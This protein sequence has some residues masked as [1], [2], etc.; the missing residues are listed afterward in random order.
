MSTSTLQFSTFML[1]DLFL[2]V[3]VL[4]V[5][6]VIRYQEMTRVPIA[7]PMVRGLINLRGQIITAIDLRRRF[8]LVDRP[9]GEL[10]MNVVLRTDDGAVS[11]LVDEIGDVVEVDE[12]RFEPIPET[13]TGMVRELI[14]GV[15]KLDNRLLLILDTE[16]ASNL[17]A[18]YS[19]RATQN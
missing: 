7:P 10:P 8:E 17:P 15:Y 9:D 4:K 2:G 3:D 19:R 11:L 6:E 14:T 1:H 5:Q 12:E 18:A 13:V 16:R